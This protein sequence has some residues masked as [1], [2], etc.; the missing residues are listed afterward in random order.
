M[1]LRVI[2]Q[3]KLKQYMNR[4]RLCFRIYKIEYYLCTRNFKIATYSHTHMLNH[5]KIDMPLY[6]LHNGN[7]GVL[8]V[9]IVSWCWDVS[10]HPARN[11]KWL[12]VTSMWCPYIQWIEQSDPKKKLLDQTIF[13]GLLPP[14]QNKCR[15]GIRTGQTFL[16]LTRFVK[17]ISNICT[18][19]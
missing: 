19:N 10:H 1:M 13:K 3:I 8:T 12:K 17:N 16:N 2:W 15:Y 5:K 9:C 11:M 4:D 7:T 18:S 14:S 6:L